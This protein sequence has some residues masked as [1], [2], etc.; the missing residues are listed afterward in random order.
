MAKTKIRFPLVAK[1]CGHLDYSAV[2]V[3]YHRVYGGPCWSCAGD[4]DEPTRA[5]W[6]GSAMRLGWKKR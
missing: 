6:R 1:A 3:T 2:A 4:P 5:F